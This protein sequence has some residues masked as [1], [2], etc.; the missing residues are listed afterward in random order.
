LVLEILHQMITLPESLGVHACESAHP[1]MRRLPH[2]V[3]HCPACGS[4]ILPAAN[5]AVRN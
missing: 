5:G 2:G 1:E 3:F 4:E